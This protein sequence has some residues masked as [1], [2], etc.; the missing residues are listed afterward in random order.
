MNYFNIY[1]I[2]INGIRGK[3]RQLYL[4]NFINTNKYIDNLCI[5]ETHIDS[6]FLSDNINSVVDDQSIWSYGSDRQCGLV[7]FVLNRNV[8]TVKYETDIDGRYI[9]VDFSYVNIQ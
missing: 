1:S 5:Q 7:V 9:F 2:N 4:K 8:K 6:Y 3:D